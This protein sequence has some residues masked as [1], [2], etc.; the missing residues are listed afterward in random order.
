MPTQPWGMTAPILIVSRYLHWSSLE[1]RAY[2]QASGCDPAGERFRKVFFRED[3]DPPNGA[4]GWAYR[5]GGWMSLP[6]TPDSP[7]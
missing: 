6:E 1:A 5:S 3:N 7:I 4:C 2:H